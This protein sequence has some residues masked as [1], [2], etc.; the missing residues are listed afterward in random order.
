[1]QITKEKLQYLHYPATQGQ[2]AHTGSPGF[3]KTGQGWA[4]DLR[5]PGTSAWLQD[6]HWDHQNLQEMDRKISKQ[7]NK[8]SVTC[9]C[10]KENSK[11]T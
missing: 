7:D 6:N 9:L 10:K 4:S 3:F 11:T 5:V 2:L 8:N 1:M